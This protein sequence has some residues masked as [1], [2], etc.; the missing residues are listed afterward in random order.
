MVHQY[1]RRIAVGCGTAVLLAG[2]MR[3]AEPPQGELVLSTGPPACAREGA[4]VEL[5]WNA[6]VCAPA[7]YVYRDDAK[8]FTGDDSTR[9][10]KATG[11]HPGPGYSFKV[12][13]WCEDRPPG[14]ML[15]S[16]NL[17]GVTI[18]PDLCESRPPGPFQL[19]SGA[20]AYDTV[21][22]FSGGTARTVVLGWTASDWADAYDLYRDG[23]LLAAGLRELGFR[24][25]Q[26]IQPGRSYTYGVRARSA[27]G[28]RDSNPV[29]VQVPGAG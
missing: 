14:R 21:S 28:A 11:L 29:T 27:K 7:Y 12:I 3:A 17:V 2:T 4:T 24:D 23:E 1:A 20:I 6:V 9:A 13:T 18:S 22:M 16:S 26:D 25:H 8:V 19:S 15:V 5:S 10:Y